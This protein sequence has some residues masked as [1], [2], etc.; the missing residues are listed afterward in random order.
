VQFSNEYFGADRSVHIIYAWVTFPT[1]CCQ[2][3]R[4]YALYS[5]FFAMLQW[6]HAA[7]QRLTHTHTHSCTIP[8]A[9]GDS[10]HVS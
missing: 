5:S 1:Q 10:H 6:V 8:Q 3:P 9:A 2:R 7:M 4:I